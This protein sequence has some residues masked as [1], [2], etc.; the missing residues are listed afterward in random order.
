MGFKWVFS[1]ANIVKVWE[2]ESLCDIKPTSNDIFSIFSSKSLTFLNGQVLPHA[3]LIIRK[4]YNQRNLE[5]LLQ[6]ST[7]RV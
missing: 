6:V 2:N 1:P 7:Q 3:F 4:L 5:R